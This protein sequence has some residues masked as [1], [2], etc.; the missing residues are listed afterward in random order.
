MRAAHL[1]F[2]LFLVA[3]GQPARDE[4]AEP[5]RAPG[6]A[7]V[8]VKAARAAEL[9]N[10]R[11]RPVDDTTETDGVTDHMAFDIEIQSLDETWRWSETVRRTAT[12][13]TESWGLVEDLIYSVAPQDLVV[14]VEIQHE[15]NGRAHIRLVC[16]DE[17]CI[18]VTGSHIEVSGTP[19]EVEAGMAAP[20]P[21]DE[22]RADNF[23]PFAEAAEAE[24][25]AAAINE[26]L[27]L[28]GA[29]GPVSAATGSSG[30]PD[31]ETAG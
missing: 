19:E 2:C 5:D 20:Q 10:A 17:P 24:E 29:Q 18:R 14:P 30:Q 16:R 13:G 26:L 15:P 3:C 31:G 1:V 27:T 9:V 8:S 6:E 11:L 12:N 4:P 25:A 22:R 21:K 23:W 28:Q 7:P